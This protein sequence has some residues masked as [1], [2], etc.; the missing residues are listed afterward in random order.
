MGAS[1][2]H[3]HG[4]ISNI[5]SFFTSW[6]DISDHKGGVLLLVVALFVQIGFNH[7]SFSRVLL[8]DVG[9]AKRLKALSTLIIT[10]LI[11]PWTILSI[12]NNVRFSKYLFLCK[13][14]QNNFINYNFNL[15][16]EIDSRH[17]T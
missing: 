17:S 7:S 11:S 14:K 6:L 13:K 5:F 9:G 3:S 1:Q 10:V 4:I 16:F 8:T 12:F 15:L 2:N